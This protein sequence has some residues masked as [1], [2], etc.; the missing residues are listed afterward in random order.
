MRVKINRDAVDVELKL[1][2]PLK[3][4]FDMNARSPDNKVKICIIL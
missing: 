2:S 4:A 3:I 1:R